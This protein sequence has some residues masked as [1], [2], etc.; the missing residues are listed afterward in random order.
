MFETL[1][2]GPAT[3]PVSLSEAKNF[4]RID[5]DITQDD[6]LL[7]MLIAAARRYA[8]SYLGRS[9]ITQTWKQVSDAFPGNQQTLV[10]PGVP[11]SWPSHAL[12]L[13]RSPVQSITS[14]QYLDMGGTLQTM[15]SSDYAVDLVSEPTRITPV[16]GKIWPVTLPQIGA[17]SVTYVAGY[18]AAAA[19][20]PEGIRQWI[21]LR[22]STLY[23]NREE[24]A[25]MSRGRIDP[26]P[27][28][29]GLLDPYRVVRA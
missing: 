3:E 1:V 24:H 4:L 23:Q 5:S 6:A 17:V 12:L 20:V 9:L 26:L 2:S 11:Y 13:G 28:I 22:L 27:F 10:M 21:L 16:F 7:T 18:G 14:V 25:V 29:D 19:A 8:E 15:S